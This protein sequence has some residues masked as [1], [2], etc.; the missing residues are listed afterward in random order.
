LK[1][2]DP[3][4]VTL[5]DRLYQRLRSALPKRAVDHGVTAAPVRCLT[6]AIGTRALQVAVLKVCAHAGESLSPEGWNSR[7]TLSSRVS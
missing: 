3:I 5:G 6:L 2:C 7:S 4:D 1:C